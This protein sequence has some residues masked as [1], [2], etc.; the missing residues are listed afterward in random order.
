[1]E[2]IAPRHALPSNATVHDLYS[3]WYPLY[4]KLHCLAAAC[5]HMRR[6][7][8]P[9]RVES[10]VF[11]RECMCSCSRTYL[12]HHASPA[13][14]KGGSQRSTS[15]ISASVSYSARSCANRM[16]TQFFSGASFSHAVFNAWGPEATRLRSRLRMRGAYREMPTYGA[17]LRARFAI[18][19]GKANRCDYECL[20]SA[21]TGPLRFFAKQLDFL[22]NT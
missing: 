7:C 14:T 6:S 5:E 19:L 17:S 21:A 15:I 20:S 1:M 13:N 10:E 8:C 3:H 16:H 9:R 11:M 18:I 22:P 4:A 2:A 12:G